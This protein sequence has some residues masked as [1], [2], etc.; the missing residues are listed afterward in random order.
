MSTTLQSDIAAVRQQIEAATA[1]LRELE[2]KAAQP[3]APWQPKGGPFWIDASSNVHTDSFLPSHA[4]CV[5]AGSSFPTQA[6]AESAATYI[7]FFRRMCC[8]AQELNPSGKV[9]GNYC[10]YWSFAGWAAAGSSGFAG[11]EYVFE[12]FA[13]ARKAVEVFNRDNIKPPTNN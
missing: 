3:P 10:I 8:L 6:A 1:K 13:V 5:I 4:T 9:G 7:T 11:A 12:S 2:Q